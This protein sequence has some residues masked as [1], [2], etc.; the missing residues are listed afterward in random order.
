MV[1]S[2]SSSSSSSSSICASVAIGYWQ[3]TE[4]T[5][6]TFRE[7][8]RFEDGVLFILHHCSILSSNILSSSSSSSGASVA[9]EY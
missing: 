3:L 8:L 2:S 1:V 4:V 6:E 7:T 9:M 5:A